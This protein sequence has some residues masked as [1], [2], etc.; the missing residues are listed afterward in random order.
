MEP[1]NKLWQIGLG[2]VVAYIEFEDDTDDFDILV[3]TLEGLNEL[4]T[5]WDDLLNLTL[6]ASAY[7]GQMAEISPDEYMEIISS[8]RV[9]EDGIYGEA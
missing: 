3:A 8:I 9:T 1:T 2:C 6:L 7:C 4:G 5:D